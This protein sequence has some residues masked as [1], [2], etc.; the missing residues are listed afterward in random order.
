MGEGRIDGIPLLHEPCHSRKI[1]EF[2][3]AHCKRKVYADEVC[4]I[5][6]ALGVS[7]EYL[8]A[9]SDKSDNAS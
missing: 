9:Q 5:A 7:I 1:R 2:D 6:E 8:F 3:G 4:Q